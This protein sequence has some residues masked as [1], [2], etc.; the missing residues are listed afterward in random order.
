R[1]V[2]VSLV[3][4]P[5]PVSNVISSDVSARVKPVFTIGR[6]PEKPG[7]H[8]NRSSPGLDGTV[9]AP[10]LNLPPVSFRQRPYSGASAEALA[11]AQRLQADAAISTQTANLAYL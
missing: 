6:S 5:P 4:T 8:S 2:H 10:F 7:Y 1:P 9:Q 11:T 3:L